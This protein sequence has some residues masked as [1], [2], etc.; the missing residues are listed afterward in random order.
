MTT[1]IG[2]LAGDDDLPVPGYLSDG[3]RFWRD[4]YNWLKECGY[5]LRRRYE[6]DWVPSWESK[7]EGIPAKRFYDCED[8]QRNIV[9]IHCCRPFE[10]S[11]IDICICVCVCSVALSWTRQASRMGLS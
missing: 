4:H 10:L 3:E 5:V 6:P 1:Q 7:E 2:D 9:R 11:K 8:G